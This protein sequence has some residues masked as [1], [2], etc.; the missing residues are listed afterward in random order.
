VF[1]RTTSLDANRDLASIELGLLDQGR[2][3]GMMIRGRS[4]ERFGTVVGTGADLNGDR[5]TEKVDLNHDGRGDLVL[6]NPNYANGRGEVV[7]VYGNPDLQSPS[8][9]YSIDDLVTLKLG[10]VIRGE[11]GSG[12]AGFNV[13]YAGDFDDDGWK[14][15]LVSA[16]EASVDMDGDGQADLIKAGKVYLILGANAIAP[17]SVLELSEVGKSIRGLVMVGRRSNDMLGG[18][19]VVPYANDPVNGLGSSG[20]RAR[21]LSWAGDVNGDGYDD[22]LVAAPMAAAGVDPSNAVTRAG[23]VYLVTGF[24]VP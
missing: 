11:P 16:P 5:I 21:S 22:I 6:G 13:S 14:D 23:E 10:S 17:G 12:K 9:G 8:G 7:I 18:G 1:R 4:G 15:L 20:M 19:E 2:R 24:D 3:I